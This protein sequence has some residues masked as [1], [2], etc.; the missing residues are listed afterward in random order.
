MLLGYSVDNKWLPFV[1]FGITHFKQT[2]AIY[3]ATMGLQ[4]DTVKTHLKKVAP[5]IRIGCNYRLNK[6]FSIRLEGEHDF[7]RKVKDAYNND[8]TCTRYSI[9]LALIYHI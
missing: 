8:L 3:V 2:R 1:M 6:P 7:K 5:F 4:S 9:K